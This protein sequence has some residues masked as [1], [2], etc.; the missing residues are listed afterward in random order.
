M[1]GYGAN[2]AA[3]TYRI[4]MLQTERVKL[5]RDVKWLN[6][7]YGDLLDLH[8]EEGRNDSDLNYDPEPDSSSDENDEI[9]DD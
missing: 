8:A 5:T 1:V 9:D 3:G 6:L 4:F 7:F 2:H